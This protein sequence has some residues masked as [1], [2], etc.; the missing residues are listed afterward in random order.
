MAPTLL[1]G[2]VESR[3][4]VISPLS[5]LGNAAAAR[6]VAASAGCVGAQQL[7]LHRTVRASRPAARGQP[8]LTSGLQLAGVFCFVGVVF[9]SGLVIGVKFFH[10]HEGA[11]LDAGGLHS[12]THN[13]LEASPH[14][15]GQAGADAA[16][17]TPGSPPDQGTQSLN[18][19]GGPGAAPGSAAGTPRGLPGRVGDESLSPPSPSPSPPPA[20]AAGSASPTSASPAAAHPSLRAV[21][22]PGAPTRGTPLSGGSLV[23][24]PEPYDGHAVTVTAWIRLDGAN[25]DPEMKTVAANRWAGCSPTAGR[26]G[27][28]LYV[29]DW[30]THNRQLRVV[31][32]N[33]RDGC[34]AVF[35]AQEAIPYDEWTHV[36]LSLGP[37]GP[38]SPVALFV[39]GRRAAGGTHA[40]EAQTMDPLRIGAH[41][42]GEAGFVGSISAVA[43]YG[44]QRTE[45][46]IAAEVSH[47]VPAGDAALLA[48]FPLDGLSSACAP[49]TL[50]P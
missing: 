42:D 5:K 1:T 9:T 32:G 48:H 27:F 45:E 29:N 31:L 18:S 16:A 15:R 33:A 11:M 28:A 39:N 3:L 36:A 44:A 38:S 8:L 24:L 21:P 14:L 30:G 20:P 35:T 7:T 49:V 47:G 37:P 26:Y 10:A 46:Q 41:S 34:V 43:V 4:C 25:K 13:T 22:T 50:C 19:Q 17:S 6:Y 2:K 12:F 40:R 23:S